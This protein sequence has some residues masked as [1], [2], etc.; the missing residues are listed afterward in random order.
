LIATVNFLVSALNLNFL[1]NIQL[2]LLHFSD[3]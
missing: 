3:T 2:L 1:V